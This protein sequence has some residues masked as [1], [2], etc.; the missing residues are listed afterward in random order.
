MLGRPTSS[1][2]GMTTCHTLH[3]AESSTFAE[4]LIFTV[5]V[6]INGAIFAWQQCGAHA[7]NN[8]GLMHESGERSGAWLK[9]KTNKGQELVI[10]DY[11]PSSLIFD[12][13]LVGYYERKNLIFIAKIKKWIYPS[14]ASRGRGTNFRG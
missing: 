14:F 8:V 1:S 10:G 9:F 13:L 12:Y 11:K 4:Q 7:P 3:T 6:K 5:Q 2:V